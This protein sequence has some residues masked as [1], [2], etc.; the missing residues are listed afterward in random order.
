MQERT[1]RT[2]TRKARV[3]FVLVL[4]AAVGSRAW[5]TFLGEES[6]KVPLCSGDWGLCLVLLIKQRYTHVM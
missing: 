6:I 4:L 1:E 2:G 3:E 5:A